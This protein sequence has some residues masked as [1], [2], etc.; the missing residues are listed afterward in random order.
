MTKPVAKKKVL[1]KADFFQLKTKV[2]PLEVEDLGTVYIKSMTAS[3]REGLE[4]Q[5]QKEVE[6]RGVRAVIFIYSVC[7]E[8]GVLEFNDEDLDTVKNF[9]SDIVSKV[10]DFSNELNGIDVSAKEGAAKN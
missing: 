10:F 5:M 7:D 6:N 1:N 8:N 3:E 9:P 2:V 4:H